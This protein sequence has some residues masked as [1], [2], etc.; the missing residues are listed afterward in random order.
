MNT[1][2]KLKNEINNRFH[3]KHPTQWDI[4]NLCNNWWAIQE[5]LEQNI[6]DRFTDISKALNVSLEDV[7]HAYIENELYHITPKSF[8]RWAGYDIDDENIVSKFSTIAKSANASIQKVKDIWHEIVRKVAVVSEEERQIAI[9]TM[10]GQ[11]FECHHNS[12]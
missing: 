5:A 4:H 7:K 12:Q 6:P 9:A 10:W 3:N 2:A 11:K 1:Y 8:S